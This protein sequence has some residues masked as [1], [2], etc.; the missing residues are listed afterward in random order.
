M[1]ICDWLCC[2]NE[3]NRSSYIKSIMILYHCRYM[4]SF[5]QG[6]FSCGSSPFTKSSGEIRSFPAVV[7]FIEFEADYRPNATLYRW[8][9]RNPFIL[10]LPFPISYKSAMALFYRNSF[11][12]YS[13]GSSRTVRCL[14]ICSI[15]SFGWMSAGKDSLISILF[16]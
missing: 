8:K 14:L 6:F 7:F 2:K 12:G 13:G 3:R 11:I 16:F 1:E 4:R 5:R 10:F 9:R 15:P